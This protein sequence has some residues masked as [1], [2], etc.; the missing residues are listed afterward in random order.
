[1]EFLR[2][3]RP[4]GCREVNLTEPDTLRRYFDVFVRLDIFHR[5][6]KR[7]LD[8]WRDAHVVVAARCPHGG[9]LLA[10]HEVNHQVVV[11]D[12]LAHDLAFIDLHAGVDEEAATILEFINRVGRCLSLFHRHQYTGQTTRN[13][14]FP[15]LV[16]FEPVRHYGFAGRSR[17]HVIA[18]ADDTPCR[19]VKLEVLHVALG[20]HDEEFALALG[21]QLD[22][23]ARDV[24]R[25][26]D[27]Q[28]FY[29]LALHA[30]DFLD[31][32]LR[33]ADLKLVTLAAHRLNQYRQVKDPPAVYEVRIGRIC[34]H[35]FKGKV[36]LRLLIQALLE[37]ARGDE[38]AFLAEER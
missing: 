12:V 14:A 37:V 13:G 30:V 10:L 7:K 4:L 2:V 15:R 1:R 25:Y 9:E 32:N 5:F 8:G 18:Q 11:A 28:R 22:D 23:L 21:N 33:L 34:L 31:D 26:V 38:L 24:G 3:H 27:H 19:D 16:G 36:F 6:F 35:H 29:R 17:K 20:L